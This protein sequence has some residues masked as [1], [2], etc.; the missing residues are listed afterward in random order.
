MFPYP[1]IKV[2]E[3]HYHRNGITGN[4]FRMVKIKVKN[5]RQWDMM[6]AVVFP[7]PGN[8]AVLDFESV[9][10]ENI[11]NCFRGDEF[12]KNLREYLKKQGEENA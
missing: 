3:T 8:C 6:L 7:E 4:G 10:Q 1:E 12:E 5:G 2:I 11:T 9:K